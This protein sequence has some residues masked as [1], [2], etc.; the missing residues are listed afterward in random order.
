MGP[1]WDP[2]VSCRP[3][4]GPMNFAIR[5]VIVHWQICVSSGLI[6]LKPHIQ[7]DIPLYMACDPAFHIWS[8]NT[9]N[10]VQHT[11]EYCR[12]I[13]RYWYVITIISSWQAKISSELAFLWGE[14]TGLTKP[15]P[16]P[17]G[18]T[19]T[20]LIKFESEYIHFLSRKCIW[21]CCLQNIDK[22]VQSSQG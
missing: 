18:F 16:G 17:I 2:P 3:Q 13:N 21:L 8:N 6:E 9:N 7:N 19:G 15:V 20:N 4:M 22:M 5:V 1:T 12:S 14:S 11:I 10:Y